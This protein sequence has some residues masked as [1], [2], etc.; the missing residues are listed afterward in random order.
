VRRID[1]LQEEL[2]NKSSAL[3]VLKRESLGKEHSQEALEEQCHMLSDSLVLCQQENKQLNKKVKEVKSLL[4][5][6]RKSFKLEIGKVHNQFQVSIDKLQKEGERKKSANVFVSRVK[7]H[8]LSLSTSVSSLSSCVFD[9]REDM[10]VLNAMIAQQVSLASK[11]IMLALR[12]TVNEKQRMVE[13]CKEEI[14]ERRRLHR[15]LAELKGRIRVF[16][17]IRPCI[18]EDNDRVVVTTVDPVD[19]SNVR[20]KWKKAIKSFTIDRAFGPECS[21][22]QVFDEVRDVVSSVMDGYNV[23]IFAYGQT[24]SGKTHTMEGTPTQPGVNVHS[25]AE[26]FTTAAERASN[27]LYCV[28]VSIVEIYSEQVYDLLSESPGRKLKI[29]QGE[30]GN[31]LPGLTWVEVKDVEEAKIIFQKGVVNRTTAA[32][33]MNLQSSRSHCV[34]C[35]HVEGYSTTTGIRTFGK[36]NMIDL[37][38]SERVSRSGATGD[39]LKEAQYIN[40]SLSSLGDVLH[41]LRA[42]NSHIPYRNSK[43]THLLKDSLG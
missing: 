42:K 41:S 13:L 6:E 28:H 38:G 17:R 22:A 31:Y 14:E 18:P 4:E 24:G 16:V 25:V 7:P 19:D 37:A 5:Q 32:T 36:L 10:R 26:I 27:W 43:L 1:L 11:K 3:R 15:K 2:E 40:K 34:V 12:E 8:L 29:K 21:Q 9:I 30:K 20:L 23:A 35:L 33:T 39:R